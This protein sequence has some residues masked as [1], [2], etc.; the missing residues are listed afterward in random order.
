MVKENLYETTSEKPTISA[1]TLKIL[2][3]SDSAKKLEIRNGNRHPVTTT[4]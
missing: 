4:H 1:L 2:E 3:D